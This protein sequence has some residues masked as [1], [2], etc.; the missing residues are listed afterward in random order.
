MLPFCKYL[1]SKTGYFHG[2]RRHFELTPAGFERKRKVINMNSSKFYIFAICAFLF[3]QGLS[4]SIGIADSHLPTS[5]TGLCEEAAKS[6]GRKIYDIN[7]SPAEISAQDSAYDFSA[8]FEKSAQDS[9][10]VQLESWLFAPHFKDG[11]RAYFTPLRLI[12]SIDSDHKC[13]FTGG[14]RYVHFGFPP[15]Q[16]RAL[17]KLLVGE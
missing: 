9:G 4:Q 14:A 11:A 15:F 16:D 7:A 8:Q 1:F 5:S 2:T 6:I 12:F 17:L 3:T 13:Y 10:G